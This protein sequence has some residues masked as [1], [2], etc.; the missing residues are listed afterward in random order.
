MLTSRPPCNLGLVF[1][2]LRQRENQSTG[3]TSPVGRRPASEQIPWPGGLCESSVSHWKD[4]KTPHPCWGTQGRNGWEIGKAPGG[5]WKKEARD[6][7]SDGR[8]GQKQGD[9][10]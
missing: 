6:V 4:S 9:V 5:F 2:C 10:D 3:G 1:S 8:W 7:R